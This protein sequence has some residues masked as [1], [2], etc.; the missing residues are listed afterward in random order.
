MLF[1]FTLLVIVAFLSAQSRC[2]GGSR[3]QAQRRQQDQH[4]TVRSHPDSAA[5]QVHGVR[6]E[7]RQIWFQRQSL[8]LVVSAEMHPDPDLSFTGFSEVDQVWV[9]P[10]KCSKWF[11]NVFLLLFGYRLPC[12]RSSSLHKAHRS[13]CIRSAQ[14]YLLKRSDMLESSR[15]CI[16]VLFV[17]FSQSQSVSQS[18][19]KVASSRA[20]IMSSVPGNN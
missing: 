19:P 9:S 7:V 8:G 3:E 15:S 5:L 6:V 16:S 13:A 14:D 2:P 20:G 4:G 18:N 17:V 11:L 10:S 1:S 12:S